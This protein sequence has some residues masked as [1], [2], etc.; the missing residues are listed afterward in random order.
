[1]NT[2]TTA[3]KALLLLGLLTPLS[4]I[5]PALAQTQAPQ[6]I[7]LPAQPLDQA[8]IDLAR[9]TGLAIGGDASLLDGKQA[10]AL[11]GDYTPEQ[12]LRALLA[13][14]GVTAVRVDSGYRLEAAPETDGNTL[15]AVSVYGRQKNDTV[16]AIPQSVSVYNREN[17]ALAQADTV[18][19]VV[20]LTPSANRAGSGRDMFA[21]DFLIRGFNA[22]ES[23]NGLGFRQTDHPTDLA[24]VER[25][26]ILKGPA[27][28]LYGQMEPGGTIN[29]VTKQPLDYYQA[30]MGAEYG[31]YDYHRTTL[32]V[33]G[34]LNDRVR[35]R[36]N[37][38]HQDSNASMDYWGYERLFVAPNVTV[39]LTDTTNLT[40][41]GSYSANE[42]T[43]LPGGAPAEGA[44]EPNPNGHYSDDFNTA[45]KDA[46]TER[47]SLYL[48]TRLV[49]AITD[50]IDARLSYA[51]TR[52]DQ[53]FQ[54]Y[55]P[56]GLGADFRTLDRIIFA[57]DDAQ[58]TDHEVILDLS[59]EATLA[60][61][62]HRF[63]AGV[64][65]RESDSTRPTQVFLVDPI[66]LYEPVYGPM[67]LS[68]K[69]RDRG[70]TQTDR[71]LAG[72]VQDRVSFA[73]KWTLLAGLRYTDAEQSQKTTDFMAGDAVTRAELGETAWTT[74]L[75]LV[76]DLTDNTSLYTSRNE[77]F[78]P[79][80]GTTSGR[81]PL[82]AE[83][84]VQ[85]EAGVRVTA[86][87][88]NINAAGFIIEKDNMAISDPL[89]AGF[90]V[91]QGRARS[92]GAELTVDGYAT[93]NL[94]L[95]AGYGYTDTEV[96]RTDDQTLEGNRF[97]NVPLHTAALQSRYYLNAVTGLSLGGTV[98]Y[99]DERPA[100][101]D[102]SVTLPA[103]TRV[104]LG[105]YYAVTDALQLDLLLNNVT[106]EEIFSP[107]SFDGV[108][109]EEGRTYLARVK[110][111]F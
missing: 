57:S 60:G 61:M 81:Q 40:V 48:N 44:I 14:S 111:L 103:Y 83:E 16:E 15:E 88:L 86:D 22:E 13:G 58:Q 27:S 73:D 5:Q 53:T 95:S 72:F 71:L 32:D 70:F 76:Y 87:R 20:R 21:D 46:T 35:A 37:L 105:A 34:P 18:G 10:P 65:Y 104:D 98:A 78:V 80:Q 91:A 12:A 108:I 109:R 29:V 51:Y 28:V 54:E 42:W 110:Y 106:D 69:A 107:G 9:Q 63:I 85:Y 4:L 64:N 24:N 52:N 38:A 41:E 99:V 45:W 56:F 102:N 19:D 100:N 11:S 62:A 93:S 36:L 8:V 55:A 59:G 30:E 67:D 84:S 82:D 25:L 68:T 2:G 31:S 17:F 101:A 89:N 90:E 26:E 33:T 75:G 74:Q 92:Q 43:A 47:D 66:D 96:L 6:T 97:V 79:Q 77:A 94:Y 39:D 49:Q 50:T 23:V 1:M 7:N 3:P